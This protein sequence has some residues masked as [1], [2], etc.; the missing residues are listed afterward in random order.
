MLTKLLSVFLCNWACM[1]KSHFRFQVCDKSSGMRH[2]V[3]VMSISINWHHL[4]RVGANQK[5][6]Q[7]VVFHHKGP[8]KN[9]V[10]TV[11]LY[12]FIYVFFLTKTCIYPSEI[13]FLAAHKVILIID[14]LLLLDLMSSPVYSDLLFTNEKSGILLSHVNFKWR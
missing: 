6:M 12:V 11:F 3:Q 14:K 1:V 5:H 10:C 4:G 7:L 9:D 13:W 2:C 8:L